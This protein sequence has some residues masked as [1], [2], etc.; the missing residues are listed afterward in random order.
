[1]SRK[2][3]QQQIPRI[4][5]ALLISFSVG[6]C[7]CSSLRIHRPQDLSN[8]QQ[9]QM[10][11]QAA[12]LTQTVAAERDRL[13]TVLTEELELVRQHTLARRDARLLYIIGE[14]DTYEA[15]AFLED[16]IKGRLKELGV[17]DFAYLKDLMRRQA[18]AEQRKVNLDRIAD[19]YETVRAK[20]PTLPVLGCPQRSE[21][22]PFS[23]ENFAAKIFWDEYAQ[24]CLKYLKIKRGRA[25]GAGMSADAPL[26]NG[27]VIKNMRAA[28]KEAKMATSAASK[29]LAT[30]KRNY[31]ESLKNPDVDAR[32]AARESMRVAARNLIHRADDVKSA[33]NK[34][35]Q[36]Q[37]TGSALKALGLDD[38]VSKYKKAE[39]GLDLQGLG[40]VVSDLISV[41]ALAKLEA[42]R[43]QLMLGLSA[44]LQGE[45]A[46]KV[47][48][49]LKAIGVALDDP[50]DAPLTAIV[51]KEKQLELDIVA[52][53]KREAFYDN[54]LA[55]LR[56][57]E[58]AYRDELA[59]LGQ[60]ELIRR[61][62]EATGCLS[63]VSNQE[64]EYL[65]QLF[66]D[67]DVKVVKCRERVFRLLAQYSAAWTIG[68]VKSEQ[69]DY[70]LIALHHESALDTSEIAFQKW[71]SLLG[72]PMNQL[73]AFY[74]TGLK[75]EDIMSIIQAL[76]LGAI[77]VGVN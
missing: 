64:S 63:E 67:K 29:A 68:R 40:L 77:A 47:F 42:S 38:L 43:G 37:D 75:P 21:A 58:A 41:P 33:L 22:D 20:E 30:A 3:M 50:A 56:E 11:F 15:W 26:A 53:R 10:Q 4:L 73:V 72:L 31:A 69:I 18:Q 45:T 49:S 7:G 70:R 65:E 28:K 55:L 16:D 17:G 25:E 61:E 2:P 71:D 76:G 54:T 60:S 62:L 44:T 12:E 52:A 19:N 13:R 46:S 59:F 74:E 66:T 36:G 39:S 48:D 5:T 6:I 32:E 51:L 14:G 34:L 9:A 35:I 8:A 57:Q 24:E 27:D 23:A 1:M